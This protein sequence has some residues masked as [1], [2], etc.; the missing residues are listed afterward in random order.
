VLTSYFFIFCGGWLSSA[1][2]VSFAILN[3]HAEQTRKFCRVDEANLRLLNLSCC[4]VT[5]AGGK[6]CTSERRQWSLVCC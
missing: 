6:S 4:A 3:S 1:N 5:S 2:D